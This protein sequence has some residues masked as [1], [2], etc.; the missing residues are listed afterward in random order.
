M[1]KHCGKAK[2]KTLTTNTTLVEMGIN[3]QGGQTQ[4][5]V[6]RHL[7]KGE[8]RG[9]HQVHKDLPVDPQPLT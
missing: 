4:H 7:G 9:S 6:M 8:L 2:G 3:S 5:A 1:R